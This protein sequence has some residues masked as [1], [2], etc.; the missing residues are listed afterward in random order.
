[1]PSSSYNSGTFHIGQIYLTYIAIYKKNLAPEQD[2]EN[3]LYQLN[4]FAFHLPHDI[5]LDAIK[6]K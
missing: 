3:V 6:V 5:R 2:S 1:M 4:T